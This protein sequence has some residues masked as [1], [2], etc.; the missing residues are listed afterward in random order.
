MRQIFS[1]ILS[2]FGQREPEAPSEL[3]WRDVPKEAR[4]DWILSMLRRADEAD[5]E[6]KVPGARSHQ[7]RL[8][9]PVG[10]DRLREI[11][12]R[13]GFTLP[14][15]Y[16]WFLTEIGNGG[17][18]P[19]QGI[20]PFEC[21]QGADLGRLGEAAVFGP[22]D[23]PEEYDAFRRQL[24]AG[25][26]AGP[27]LWRGLLTVSRTG[28]AQD[29]MLAVT[30]P[31]RGR[32]LFVEPELARPYYSPDVSFLDWYAR[33]LEETAAG[34]DMAFFDNRMSGNADELTAQYA[35]ADDQEKTQILKA[36]FKFRTVD[37]MIVQRLVRLY[38]VEQNIGLKNYLMRHLYRFRYAKAED[39]LREALNDER[40][41]LQALIALWGRYCC[42]RDDRE[43]QP[44]HWYR[45]VLD[46]LPLLEDS[47]YTGFRMALDLVTQS[48]IFQ[49]EDLEALI[50]SGTEEQQA[51]L[52]KKCSPRAMPLHTALCYVGKLED[53]CRGSDPRAIG[54]WMER[55]SRIYYRNPSLQKDLGLAMRPICLTLQAALDAGRLNLPVIR[56]SID[57]I[58]GTTEPAETDGPA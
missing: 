39:M 26:P 42:D 49:M 27:A 2:K 35:A 43:P 1:R 18:G 12:Q 3:S 48:P 44:E 6:R 33:W 16:F 55:C 24:S 38:G 54:I 37:E 30:G 14:E 32:L 40:S 31:Q 22:M 34:Y 25:Q 57:L 20:L 15:D 21:D 28:S 5:P 50:L 10:A 7:Y 47:S 13:F 58:L 53:S 23:S 4:K 9:P 17:A 41:R 36:L 11:Q 46:I 52:F 19:Y 8:N 45:E 56:E 51:I 29:I